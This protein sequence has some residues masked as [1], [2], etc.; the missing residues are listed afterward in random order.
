M[1]TLFLSYN[2]IVKKLMANKVCSDKFRFL[3]AKT[4]TKNFNVAN[5]KD[6]LLFDFDYSDRD[7]FITTFEII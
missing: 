3:L 4:T 5:V 6:T 1:L 7:K 2:S